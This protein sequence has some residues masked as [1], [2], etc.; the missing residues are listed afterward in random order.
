M[1]SNAINGD[2]GCKIGV[3]KPVRDNEDFE[4]IRLRGIIELY[5]EGDLVVSETFGSKSYRK[6]IIEKWYAIYQLHN[7]HGVYFQIKYT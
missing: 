7:K 2:L 1:V 3:K 6:E 4:V 5:N